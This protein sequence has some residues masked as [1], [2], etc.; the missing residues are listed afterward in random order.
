MNGGVQL[1]KAS[2]IVRKGLKS[3]TVFTILP[4]DVILGSS[5]FFDTHELP[6]FES[7]SKP[8]EISVA[9]NQKTTE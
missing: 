1:S 4:L 2:G 7:L 8:E 6:L 9:C 3:P 5:I